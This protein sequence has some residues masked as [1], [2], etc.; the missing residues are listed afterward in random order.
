MQR[1]LFVVTGA[2]LLGCS[3]VFAQTVSVPGTPT[4][5]TPASNGA[6]MGRSNAMPSGLVGTS[7]LGTI[8]GNLAYV[9]PFALG[10][11]TAC[12]TG[13]VSASA[14]ADAEASAAAAGVVATPTVVSPLGLSSPAN[15]CTTTTLPPTVAPGAVSGTAFG[16]GA[17]PLDET[18][19]GQP[20]M[21]PQIAVPI[22]GAPTACVSGD[23]LP[24]ASVPPTISEGADP[25]A[26]P[27]AQ[28]C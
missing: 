26:M 1:V 16:D 12:P 17:V 21:S 20:G 18:E 8:Q 9:S 27:A 5:P 14:T 3:Q 15:A 19:A 10:S 24:E 25:A 7:A 6:S 23:V 2:V 4:M 11:I 28:P 22:P 13:V